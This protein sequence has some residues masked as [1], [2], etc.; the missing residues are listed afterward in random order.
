MKL[1]CRTIKSLID[2]SFFLE[3]L[4]LEKWFHSPTL[5]LKQKFLNKR[6][7]SWITNKTRQIYI[8]L[9]TNSGE[10]HKTSKDFERIFLIFIFSF[11]TPRL[12]SKAHKEIF[13]FDK[14]KNEFR[15]SSLF[16][17]RVKRW[18][19]LCAILKKKKAWKAFVM[20]SLKSLWIMIWHC[21]SMKLNFQRREKLSKC[22]RNFWKR[23]NGKCET[24]VESLK[25]FFSNSKKDNKS[26]SNYTAKQSCSL[27]ND[28]IYLFACRSFLI[29]FWRNLNF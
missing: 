10:V 14:R 27:Q 13:S 16:E 22:R 29:W 18:K 4:W 12:N 15:E 2:W 20:F 24:Q 9:T 11:T 3:S 28:I 25:A 21:L 19:S 6:R 17:S 1:I 23:P 26:L 5:N 7:T 8:E